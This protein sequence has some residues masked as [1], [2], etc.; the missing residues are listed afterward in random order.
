MLVSKPQTD[1]AF[2]LG[3]NGALAGWATMY[4]LHANHH[5]QGAGAFVGGL[6]GAGLG[7]KMGRGMTEAD[8]VGAAFGSDIGALIG[9]G[10]AEA[11]NGDTGCKQRTD[12]TIDCG[13]RLSDRAVVTL[14][15]ASGVI[16]YP[17]GVLYP[18]N[19]SYNVTAG[20]IQTLWPSSA[21][22]VLTA[23]AFLNDNVST[24]TAAAVLTSGGVIGMIVGDR[25]LVRNFDHSRADGGR[26]SLGALFGGLIGAG[27][28]SLPNT[29]NPNPQLVSG[30]AALGGLIGI[31]ATE[32]YVDASPDA[33][34]RGMRLTFNPTSIFFVAAHT[35][36]NHSLL[37]VRF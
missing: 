14:V 31:I 7:L 22:G 36:G 10:T 12:G 19:A 30:L 20:D 21:I 28:A 32:R 15:L 1:L 18:R 33:G 23:S 17:L 25:F 6:A 35:P 29:R 34:R 37:N 5:G 4:L 24:S 11:I 8:A 27:V 13:G 16:G 2:N 9:F 3:H 26:V